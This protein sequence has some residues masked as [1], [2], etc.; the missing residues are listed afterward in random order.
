[1][2]GF[3]RL[4]SVMKIKTSDMKTINHK[5]TRLF[6]SITIA[7]FLFASCSPSAHIEKDDSIN[8][9]NYKT[10]SWIDS[11]GTGLNDHNRKNDI[12]EKKIREAVNNE[13]MKQGWVEVKKNPDLFLS[14]DVLLEKNA[15]PKSEAVYS[16]PYTRTFYNTYTRRWINV[17]YPSRFLGYDRY[18]VTVKERTVTITMIDAKSDLTV[19][20]GWTTSEINNRNITS[21]EIQKAVNSIFKKFDV[22]KR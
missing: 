3:L 4:Y 17:Y 13:L 22:A 11:D 14:Y 9:R 7:V 8:F 15:N 6:G 21:K 20:Q 19:W 2:P 12:E 10:F 5:M 18:E 1:M 16:D